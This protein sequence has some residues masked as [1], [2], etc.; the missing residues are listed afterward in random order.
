MRMIQIPDLITTDE[1][2]EVMDEVIHL[3]LIPKFDELGMNAT[4]EWKASLNARVDGLEGQI[5]G[6]D[7]TK[8]LVE[9]RTPGGMPPVSQIERWVQAKFG[10]SGQRATQIAWAVAKKIQRDGTD[11]YPQGTDLLEVLY[12]SEVQQYIYDKLAVSI[13]GKLEV[14][15]NREFRNVFIN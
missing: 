3:F 8:Y 10:Y 6:L 1:L 15:L 2:L 7:Y 4:G 12:S 11:Y 9:G 13:S 14:M 5:W